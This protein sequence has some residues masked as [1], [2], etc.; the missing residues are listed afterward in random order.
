MGVG[1]A[2]MPGEP[3]GVGVGVAVGV[4]VGAGVEP[5][6][7]RLSGVLKTAPVEFQACTTTL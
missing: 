1:V 3:R 5:L 2:F 4:G 7:V 6:T